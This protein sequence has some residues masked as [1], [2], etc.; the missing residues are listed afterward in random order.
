MA[1]SRKDHLLHTALKLFNQYG[2]HATGIDRVQAESGVSK[3]TMYKY[4]KT[5]DDLIRAVL[6]LRHEQFGKWFTGRVIKIS[7]E[8]Y[9]GN[10]YGKLMAMF[11]AV[12]EWIHSETFFG[13]NFI[14]ASAEFS[15]LQHP[16][17]RY[18]ADH[19]LELSEYI[20][21][22]VPEMSAEDHDEL[23]KEILLLLD[24][25]IVCA[26]TTGI[27]DS[28]ERAK[29]MMLMLLNN[30]QESAPESASA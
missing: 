20:Q 17:H 22:C 7:R 16:I 25:A 12:D 8:R 2:F 28:A 24:G 6:E 10:R 18:A 15:D 29:R 27:K 3:T 23:A 1:A 30:F 4:F 5:K 26:H 21:S 11:D 9:P 13:C 14:N 19:K